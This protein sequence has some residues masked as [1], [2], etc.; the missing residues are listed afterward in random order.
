MLAFLPSLVYFVMAPLSVSLAL[1]LGFAAAFAVG[2]RGFGGARVVRLFDLCGLALF[3]ALAL[4]AGFVETGIGPAET[5][6]VLETGF[7]VA[8]IWSLAAGRPFTAQY[9]WFKGEHDAR[10]AFRLHL[11]IAVIWMMCYGVMAA[12]HA[13]AV[14]RHELLPGPAGVLGLVVF[15]GTLTFTWQFARTIDRGAPPIRRR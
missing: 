11:S 5:G 7:L 14:F 13:A 12:I 3:G 15:V 4:Y 2:L 10:T 6:M 9:H 1:W 8:I